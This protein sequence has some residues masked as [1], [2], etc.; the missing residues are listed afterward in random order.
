[1]TDGRP[2]TR[3]VT[4]VLLPSGWRVRGL[5]PTLGELIRRDA[6]PTD[7]LEVALRRADP[8]W[9]VE[10]V[11]DPEKDRAL[12]RHMAILIAAYATEQW[13][14]AD[15][16]WVPLRLR[17]DDFSIGDHIG[18][19]HPDD[20]DALEVIIRRQLTASAVSL[21]SALWLKVHPP[22]AMEVPDGAVSD[23]GEFRGESAG[24]RPGRAVGE[25]GLPPV[26]PAGGR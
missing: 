17:E 22:E 8:A 24:R 13:S 12:I 2:L 5:L 16:A 26:L 10:A 4:E 7:L 11:K 19:L 1:M 3:G 21:Q 25:V 23:W 9:L 20:I 15:E 14:E 18:I 6:L